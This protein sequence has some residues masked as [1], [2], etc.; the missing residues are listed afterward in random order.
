M[1]TNTDDKCENMAVIIRY[2]P[3]NKP[4]LICIEHAEDSKK[5]ADAMGFFLHLE[6]VGYSLVSA[7]TEFPFRRCC[8]SKGFSQTVTINDDHKTQDHET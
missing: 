2:W 1:T 7:M 3:G 8:C 6:P 4:D 5:I